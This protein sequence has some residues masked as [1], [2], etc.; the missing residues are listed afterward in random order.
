M[1][2]IQYSRN[3][4]IKEGMAFPEGMHR[5]ALGV[6]Y[7]GADFNG[8]QRQASTPNTVQAHIEFALSAIA[9]E[10]ISLVCAGRTDAG[11]HATGQVVHF[12][13]LAERPSKAWV[14]GANTKLPD[15]VRIHW[16]KDVSE[17][18]HARFCAG[19]RTYRYIMRCGSTRSATLG[20]LV[21]HLPYDLEVAAMKSAATALIGEHDFSAFRAA[22]CQA[23][24]PNRH[25][26]SITWF[27]QGELL[28][29]EIQANAFLHHMVRNIV[30][31]LL[32]VG[33]G[34]QDPSWIGSVLG[35]RDRRLAGATAAP[36][37]LYLVSVDYSDTF[38][39]PA[40]AKGP[41]FL[42]V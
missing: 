32:E 31:S 19:A 12:D 7:Q 25:I 15:T 23:H 4:E 41:V 9:Q 10:D 2:E 3:C 18:F 11:V 8:F 29:M 37:G 39:L 20:K 14:L 42:S 21:T 13:T 6:E 38:E 27:Q 33:R 30:G 40:T 34:A 22:Q 17:H 35:S 24:N 1:A 28:V 16:S 26:H 36:W 5:V